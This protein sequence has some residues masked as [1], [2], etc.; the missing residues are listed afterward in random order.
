MGRARLGRRWL[1]VLLVAV[2]V[3][4]V[5]SSGGA[6][7]DPADPSAPSVWAASCVTP[8]AAELAVYGRGFVAAPVA[9]EVTDQSGA[10]VGAATAGATDRQGAGAVFQARVA[11]AMPT[12]A[13]TLLL[14]ATQSGRQDEQ[15][16]TVSSSSCT[17]TISVTG[18]ATCATQ[19]QPVPITVTVRGAP[20][21]TFDL[22]LHHIDLYGPAEAVDRTQ[23]PRPNGDYTLP[24]R[25]P[26]VPGRVV[27]VTL[28]ARRVAGGFA[29]A[30][31]SF[32][33]PPACAVPTTAPPPPPVTNPA[34]TQPTSAVTTATTAPPV[35]FLPPV[36][37]PPVTTGPVTL[38]VSPALG[39]TG[40]ATTVTGSGFPASVTLTLRWR[41]GIGEWPVTTGGDGSFRTQ[42][43]VL[44]KDVE[45]PRV[46]EVLEGGAPPASYL[47]VPSSDQP[48][49]GGVFVRG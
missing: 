35:S 49:F 47:V 38:A 17:P 46:L 15:T 26:G 6:Q 8:G 28:E 39:R 43:L 20:L 16:I 25:V 13:T 18:P 11:L 42:V 44:P 37:R 40:E 3:L 7:V 14:T 4:G 36:V 12:G 31:T 1:P 34:T 10:L 2:L 5:A 41:P 21:E 45:G 27:P 30:T 48:A 9:V 19:G 33:Q 29:Y 32:S 23:P 24:L 22:L